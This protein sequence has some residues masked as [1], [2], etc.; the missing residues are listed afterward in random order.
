MLTLLIS[1]AFGAIVV[2]LA[3][4]NAGLVE[5]SFGLVRIT[6]PLFV[7]MAVCFLMGFATAVVAFI[8]KVVR[9]N[10]NKLSRGRTLPGKGIVA[11]R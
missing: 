7:V 9:G 5:I 8:L 11:R 4:S 3:S 6:T 1:L 10:G 2:F